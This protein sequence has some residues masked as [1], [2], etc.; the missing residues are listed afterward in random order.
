MSSIFTLQLRMMKNETINYQ[1]AIASPCD[2]CKESPCCSLLQLQQLTVTTLIDLDLIAYYLN[3]D[4]IAVALSKDG[5]WTIYYRYPCRFLNE[6]DYSCSVHNLPVQPNICIHYN[7]YS[8]FYKTAEA[9]KHS[10]RP[11]L[12]WINY[13][14]VQHLRSILQ[15]DSERKI[16]PLSEQFNLFGLLAE[17]PYEDPPKKPPLPDPVLE[18]WKEQSLSGDFTPLKRSQAKRSFQEI[19]NLCNGCDAYCCKTLLFPQEI[20]LTYNNLD[21]YRYCL[22]FPGVELGISNTQWTI[23]IKTS[24]RHLDEQ[25]KCSIYG[26]EDRPL[27]CK[28]YDA[29][30]CTYKVAF[31]EIRPQGYMR[32][33]YEELNWLLDTYQF[34]DYGN[35]TVGWDTETLQKY[36]ENKWRENHLTA[37]V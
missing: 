16:I 21:F 24:C 9:S 30:H 12:I 1:Q 37:E 20:P 23:V 6:T 10:D 11:N 17:I 27:I 8:C 18:S 3:F 13:E 33:G 25:N 15:F 22:G 7:P 35:I 28:Y 29:G 4:N 19:Q 31:G 5:T 36:I 32:V 34:D 14:R 26:K 2:T